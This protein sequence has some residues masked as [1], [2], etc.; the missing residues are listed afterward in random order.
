MERKESGKGYSRPHQNI[1]RITD[2]P[3]TKIRVWYQVGHDLTNCKHQ[4][5]KN[6]LTYVENRNHGLRNLFNFRIF[7]FLT[8]FHTYVSNTLDLFINTFSSFKC[9][10]NSEKES[11][12]SLSL[13][14]SIGGH[15]W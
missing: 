14:I 8:K 11:F 12:D 9:L 4:I 5:S 10:Y 15:G 13:T 3:S 1:L 2:I 6:R 7:T